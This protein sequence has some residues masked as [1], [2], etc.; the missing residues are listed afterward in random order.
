M[1]SLFYI[2]CTTLPSHIIPFA[3]F[4]NFRWR[5]RKAA[6]FWVCMNVLCKMLVAAHYIANGILFRNMELVFALLGFGVYL[7]FLQLDPFKM[8]FT[9]ILIVD[10][11]LIVRGISSFLAVRILETSAQG[12]ASS[13]FCI[14][15]YCV[16]LPLLIGFFRRVA[17]QVYHTHAPQLWRSIW[18]IP[19]LFT[20]LTLIFTN[21]YLESNVQGYL[22]LVSRLGLLV[23]VFAIYHVLLQTLESFQKQIALEQ[24]LV[25]EKRMTEIQMEEQKKYSMLIMENARQTRQQRHD[26][27]HQLT[28]IQALAGTDKPEL[29]N[30]VRALIEE[31]PPAVTTYCED[32]TVNS[33]VSHYANRCQQEQ[34][35]LTVQLT[36]PAQNAH[37]SDSNLCVIFGNLL[38]NALEACCRMT[39][40]T[41]FIQLKSSLHCD[42]LT[43]TM[44]NSFQGEIRQENGRFYSSK[45]DAF[46]V[47]LSSVQ[48]T[49]KDHQGDAC[50]A[51]CDGV[52][53]SSVYLTL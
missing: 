12:W 17:N 45:R 19:G 32:F 38:E 36:V 3:L 26:L 1:E 22:F 2:L 49:A 13:L 14:L 23:C 41:R 46:G 11:L 18:L 6:L 40:G 24:Q 30:Y 39:E 33:V 37:I 5:S 9:Y 50:F 20:A 34:I 31:M 4:W 43:I 35:A 53:S 47:G 44:D 29:T 15:L 48:Q 10:Y 42:V 52:F 51:A 21:S 7:I 16:T 25:F 27:H 28:A 8:L